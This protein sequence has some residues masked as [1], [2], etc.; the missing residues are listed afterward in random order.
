MRYF[1]NL[2]AGVSTLEMLNRGETT[3][4]KLHFFATDHAYRFSTKIATFSKEANAT[5]AA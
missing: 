4:A 2:R 1:R 3:E 5:H